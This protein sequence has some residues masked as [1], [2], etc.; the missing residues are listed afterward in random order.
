MSKKE[1]GVFQNDK[2]YGG[3]GMLAGQQ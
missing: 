3:I 1:I 2:L